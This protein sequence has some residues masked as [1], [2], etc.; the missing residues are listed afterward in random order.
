MCL[1]LVL[2][3]PASIPTLPYPVIIVKGSLFVNEIAVFFILQLCY[4]NSRGD[5]V[6][7]R[8]EPLR[9]SIPP[10]T[11][12][13]GVGRAPTR[14]FYEFFGE[15]NSPKNGFSDFSSLCDVKNDYGYGY[16]LL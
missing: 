14:V 3:N 5:S 13:G 11:P 10:S 15:V 1:C 9:V 4:W 6:P 2:S 16:L 7:P 8:Y 12:H